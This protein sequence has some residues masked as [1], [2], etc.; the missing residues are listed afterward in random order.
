MKIMMF[1]AIDTKDPVAVLD[2]VQTIYSGIFPKGDVGFVGK[3][4]Q[5]AHDS[6]FFGTGWIG[7]KIRFNRLIG[8]I[9]NW[10]V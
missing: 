2:E 1:P 10:W 4:F 8:V 5:T 9:T 6:E 7:Q 3:A